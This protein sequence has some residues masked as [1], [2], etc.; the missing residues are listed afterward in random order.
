MHGELNLD[1]QN[2]SKTKKLTWI[3]NRKDLTID[4]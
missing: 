2:F 3:A 1:D 4:V